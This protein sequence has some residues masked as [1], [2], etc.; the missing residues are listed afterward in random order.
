ME[1]QFLT[2]TLSLG[3][4]LAVVAGLVIVFYGVKVV[5]QSKVFVVERFGRYTKTLGAGL[6][7]IVPFFDHVAHRLSILERQL[8]AFR[9][10]VITKDNVEVELQTIVFF[11]IVEAEKSV[12]RI[13]NVDKAISDTA[14]S[15]V[16]S[17]AGT[18]ELDE[19]QSSREQMNQEIKV[20]LG[21]AA[22]VW[23]VEITRT[24]IV[25]VVVDEQTK[26]AQRKQLNAE[27]ERRATVAAAE[28]EKQAVMLRADGNL[29]EAQKEAEAVRV[30]ADAEAYAVR[31][32]AEADADQTRLLAE[33][34]ATQGQP[35]V[36]FEIRKRQVQAIGELAAA[37]NSKTIVVPAEVVGVLGA[38]E[39]LG[40]MLGNRGGGTPAG[41]Q[42]TGATSNP[43]AATSKQPRTTAPPTSAGPWDKP[44][45][46]G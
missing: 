18:Q 5:P 7:L 32:K 34:I 42:S 35:A 28:G 33:A 11:R 43:P 6:N 3:V 9:I 21:E 31:K 17:A 2:G 27:R 29:Y 38:L 13:E 10:S 26:E 46:D 36:D 4:L 39:S 1:A 22:D 16:R 40:T 41:F 23:G 44:A 14:E 30:A 45:N 15:I 37:N 20:N 19:L 25:D 12:Y 8:P 24:E